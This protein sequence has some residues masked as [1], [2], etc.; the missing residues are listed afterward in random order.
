MGF[1]QLQ[2]DVANL[3]H[4]YDTILLIISFENVGNVVKLVISSDVKVMQ[5]SSA[6]YLSHLSLGSLSHM[7]NDCRRVI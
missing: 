2:K 1:H 6:I 3:Y 4:L 7:A 5:F